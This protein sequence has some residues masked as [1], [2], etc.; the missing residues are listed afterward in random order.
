[1]VGVA[2]ATPVL[3]A[4]MGLLRNMALLPSVGTGRLWLLASV[5]PANLL[6]WL[7]FNGYLGRVGHRSVIGIGLAA[8]TFILVG[9][10]FGFVRGRSAG[11]K[12]EGPKSDS[13]E[14]RVDNIDP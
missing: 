8:L 10:V 1:M 2:V 11:R 14:P 9:S 7:V 13:I 12:G 6:I 3:A 5:G 4:A